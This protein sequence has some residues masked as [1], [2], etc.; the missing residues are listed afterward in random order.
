MSKT[1]PLRPSCAKPAA[2]ELQPQLRL[3]D[4]AGADDHGQRPRQQSAAQQFIESFHA[5]GE[6]GVVHGG[7]IQ[8]YFKFRCPPLPPGEGRGEGDTVRK[9]S[10]RPIGSSRTRIRRVVTDT[11]AP[12]STS[13]HGDIY[14]LNEK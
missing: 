9:T 8:D 5:G 13:A 2:G 14:H 6:S 7:I 11:T 3:A 12:A 10:H 4:A 1:M